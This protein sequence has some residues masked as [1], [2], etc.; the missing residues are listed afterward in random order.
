MAISGEEVYCHTEMETNMKDSLSKIR[1]KAWEK[2]IYKRPKKTIKVNS[3]TTKLQVKEKSFT[4]T[5]IPS[6]V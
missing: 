3:V 6:K 4:E 2:C 1:K 5:E